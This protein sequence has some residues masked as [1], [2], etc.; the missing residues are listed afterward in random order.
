MALGLDVGGAHEG[1]LAGLLV[2]EEG[3]VLEVFEVA[4]WE[5]CLLNW[6]F[7]KINFRLGEE[8]LHRRWR[9]HSFWQVWLG[10]HLP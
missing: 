4:S 6:L 7:H 9:W 1:V 8:I 3:L 5:L 2:L 10:D